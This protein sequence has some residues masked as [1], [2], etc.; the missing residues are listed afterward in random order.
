MKVWKNWALAMAIG[1]AL[2]ACGEA[3]REDGTA[4]RIE[5]RSAPAA[6]AYY[7]EKP[8]FF[9][10]AGP[11]DVPTDLTW[12]TGLDLPDLGSPNA[13]KGGTW[14]QTMQDFPRTLRTTGPD[15]NGAFRSYLLDDVT[16][17]FASRHPNV[18]GAFY[19]GL[20]SSWA[21]SASTKTVYVKINPKARWSD[22][23]QI[24]SDDMFFMFYFFQSSH[25]QAPWYNNWY[26]TQYK[27]ITKYDDLT[28]S[29][30]MYDARPDMDARVLG[31]RPQPEHFYHDFG[32][33]FVE[34]Y[35]WLF[36]P[37]TG[38]YI[39]KP[40][41][42]K[43]GRAITLTRDNDW[44]LKDAKFFR[45]RFNPD[46][47][48]VTVI[49]DTPK[50]FEAFR[51]GELDK[52]TLNLSEYWYD[53]LPD[54]DADVAAGYIHKSKFHN[55]RPRPMFGLYLNQERAGLDD[56]DLRLGLQHAANWQA[57]ADLYF[58]GDA[59]RMNTYW[60]GYGRFADP[61]IKAREFS[62][63]K[64]LAYFA[65][66]GFTQRGDDGILRNAAGHKL[67][68]QLTSGF[69]SMK[70]VLI[71]LK[72]EG[73]K[74][75]VEFRLEFLD[76]S[77]AWKKVREKK[78][79]IQ[80]TAFSPFNEPFP[81]F[82]EFYH[83]EN[84]YDAPYL[85]DGTPNPERKVKAQTSNYFAFADSEVDDWI[86]RYRASESEEEMLDLAYRIENRV[87]DEA[88][89]IPGF[90]RPFYRVGHWRWLKYP[91]DFN[92]RASGNDQEFF[93]HWVD[94]DLKAETLAAQKVGDKFLP[95]IN[96][97]DQYKEE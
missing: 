56:K 97:Y 51:K 30:E 41:G 70:D 32:E 49:R 65:K 7:T 69:D 48:R 96:V 27:N 74:A 5:D 87:H 62:I 1:L 76:N 63:D 19:P 38:P 64:A 71:I 26:S 6:A 81:R 39:I 35:Q 92:V 10:F 16:V 85:E 77:T 68:F 44:W 13:K 8:E 67:T 28:F 91:E 9:I 4:P 73:L 17:G 83:G 11:K 52:T 18:D 86:I 66:A 75:G 45:N 95:Q 2:V 33:D 29:V 78:H 37:T 34:K 54:D 31:L 43:K 84:A 12:Q 93:L 23:V 58:R 21:V 15:A 53:K 82:W 3:A 72:E 61:T 90:V 60:D 46:R 24:T 25:I 59:V 88:V 57:V 55:V 22:G 20:A 47:V 89:F 50:A 36:V 80:F 14:N 79:E 40:G 94:E 42:I